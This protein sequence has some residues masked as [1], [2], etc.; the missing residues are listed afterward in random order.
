MGLGEMEAYITQVTKPSSAWLREEQCGRGQVIIP[1]LGWDGKWREKETN[2]LYFDSLW[3]LQLLNRAEEHL[4]AS[5]P[6]SRESD[7]AA[8]IPLCSGKLHVSRNFM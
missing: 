7:G 6:S 4:S 8:S 3:S 1:V 5:C 2:G